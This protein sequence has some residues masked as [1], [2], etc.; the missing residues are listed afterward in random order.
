MSDLDDV[1]FPAVGLI[2]ELAG[3]R[4]LPKPMRKGDTVS[5]EG[6]VYR[7]VKVKLKRTPG[8]EEATLELEPEK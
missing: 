1:V 8:F 7:I 3:R 2:T 5:I 4:A 6:H